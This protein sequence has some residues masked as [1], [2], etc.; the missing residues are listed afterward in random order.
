MIPASSEQSMPNGRRMSPANKL[1]RHAWAVVALGS[2]VGTMGIPSS[3]SAEI[4]H[5]AEGTTEKGKDGATR[6]YYNRAAGLQWSRRLGDWSDASD[7]MHGSD[8]FSS[9][10]LSGG[11]PD[12]ITI[13]VTDLVGKWLADVYPNQGLMLRK[14]RGGGHLTL[15]SKEARDPKRTPVLIIESKGQ[16]TVLKPEADTYLAPSTFR[17]QGAGKSLKLGDNRPILMRFDLADLAGEPLERATLRLFV[18]EAYRVDGLRIGVY[19]VTPETNDPPL[20]E[21]VFGLAADAGDQLDTRPEVLY[22]ENFESADWTERLRGKFRPRRNRLIG[23][24]RR[25]GFHPHSGKALAVTIPQGEKGGLNLHYRFQDNHGFEPEAMYV[26]YYLMIG[27]EWRAGQGGKLPGLSGTYGNAGWGGRR[28]KGTNGWSARGLYHV[29]PPRGNP[30]AGQVPVGSYVYHLDTGGFYGEHML[31]TENAG[32]YLEKGRWYCIE[33]Y[34]RLNTPG[35]DD[36]MLKGWINGVPAL[37]RY[38]LRF[39]TTDAL[40]IE[41]LWLNVF[42]GGM[43][44]APSPGGRGAV[45]V[46]FGTGVAILWARLTAG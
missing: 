44:E 13:D 8:A 19:R 25:D 45:Y 31:W 3:A 38:N 17:S 28:A 2:L 29:S 39:R 22:V 18:D 4:K 43:A 20:P 6:K 10:T 41:S 37:T 11:T 23:P 46:G 9:T 7:V 35:T 32:G 26:R 34:V 24:G 33:Q 12:E 16:R 36:G 21:A 1:R 42:H 15:I 30:L 40:K 5:W 14:E 27:P